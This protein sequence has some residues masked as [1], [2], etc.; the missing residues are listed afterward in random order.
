MSKGTGPFRFF[1]RAGF[2]THIISLRTS[3]LAMAKS[4]LAVGLSRNP[5]FRDITFA[6]LVGFASYLTAMFSGAL[7][8]RPQMIWPLWP[9]CAFLVAIL[10]LTPQ[11]IWPAL[12]GSGLAGFVISDLQNGLPIRS[13]ALLIASDSIEILAAAFGVRYALGQRPRLSGLASFAKYVFFAVIL[14]PSLAACVGAAA[15][16]YNYISLWKLSFF[17]EAL[18]L[19]SL[20]PAIL[21]WADAVRANKS[22]SYYVEL[23]ALVAALN[24]VGFITFLSS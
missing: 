23:G 4:G 8:L 7:A 10:L 20:T 6:C 3:G 1:N 13:I 5:I 18:A 15:F 16:P 9:G 19:L 17:T 2:Q 24:V 21:S 14:A 12:L 11:R 22:L